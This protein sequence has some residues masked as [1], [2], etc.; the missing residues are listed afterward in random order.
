MASNLEKCLETIVKTFYKYS[1]DNP[2]RAPGLNR[3]QLHDLIANELNHLIRIESPQDVTAMML[4]WDKD[5][6][7]H[8]NLSEF[9]GGL[10]DLACMI[11][12][13][14]WRHGQ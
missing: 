1:S 7:Q 14:S 11:A 2:G 6:D 4:E 12:H 13:G 9:L 3:K 10:S 5:E 8:I